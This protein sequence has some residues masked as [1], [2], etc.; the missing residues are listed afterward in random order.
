MFSPCFHLLGNPFTAGD[1]HFSHWP[2][3]SLTI[4]CQGYDDIR[5]GVCVLLHILCWLMFS[6]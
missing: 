6:L 2:E 5:V 3:I 4:L 1:I